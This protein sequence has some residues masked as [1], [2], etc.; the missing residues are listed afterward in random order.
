MPLEKRKESGEVLSF[1]TK[2]DFQRS[3]S[4]K[5]EQITKTGVFHWDI[6]QDFLYC[7]DNFFS[8]AQISGFQE[9]NKLSVQMFFSLIE[10]EKKNYVL[11]VMHECIILN[12]EFEITFKLCVGEKKTLRMHG[13]P[14]GNVQKKIMT[15]FVVDVSEEVDIDH[16][17]MMG[18]DNER[19][20]ISMELHDSVGQKCVAV[21]YMLNL[22]QIEQKF[23][24]IGTLTKSMDEIIS[25]VRSITHNLSME[26]VLEVGLES[27][28]E[29]IVTECTKAIGAKM[30][31]IYDFPDAYK[32]PENSAKMIYRIVQEALSNTMKYSKATKVMVEI[33]HQNRQIILSIVDNGVGYDPDQSTFGIGIQNIRKRVGY[34]N[35]YLNIE[36]GPGEGTSIKIK[37]PI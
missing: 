3:L 33:K 31:F 23:D 7:S 30:D 4:S 13:F 15:G 1:S 9:S 25:E 22:M 20:R 10:Q 12:Q 2:E 5:M 32:V 27:A 14:E 8:I 36:T 19:K 17:V 6:S 11:E 34:L 37:I 21:K 28:V 18:Q 35:G 26:I 29:Q 24:D 16:R